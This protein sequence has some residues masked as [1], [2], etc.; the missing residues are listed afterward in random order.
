VFA[1][2]LHTLF[3][4]LFFPLNEVEYFNPVSGIS[5]QTSELGVR[6]VPAHRAGHGH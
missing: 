2:L 3:I 5:E 1:L 6:I 4:K